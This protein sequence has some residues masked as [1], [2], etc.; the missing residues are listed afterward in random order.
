MALPSC[1]PRI[2]YAP[3]GLPAD[4][5]T[6]ER[7][8]ARVGRDGFS[9]VLVPV[10]WLCPANARSLAPVDAD[11]APA[12]DGGTGPL[13]ARLARDAGEAAKHGLAL[14]LRLELQR[15][16]RDAVDSTAPAAWYH[17]PVDDPARDPRLSLAEH[18]VR[19]LREDPPAG[20][21]DA[22]AARLLRWTRAGGRWLR[23]AAAAASRC[24]DMAVAVRARA[25]GRPR[26]ALP[27]LDAGPGA[28]GPG[29]PA[30]RGL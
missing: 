2:Y 15:V 5:A 20:F 17:Y 12:P 3:S 26:V 9:A 23:R 30:R 27:G 11:R 6:R 24:A 8:L 18:G 7:L 21:V 4:D 1:A 19:Q 10:P 22:W 16:A 25:S 29:P 28:S 14:L 13:P